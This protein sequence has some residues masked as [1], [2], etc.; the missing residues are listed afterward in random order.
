MIDEAEADLL[1]ARSVLGEDAFVA[2]EWMAATIN[3]PGDADVD[4]V[5]SATVVT[6]R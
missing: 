5:G 2:A 1:D 3:A 4:R 6:T